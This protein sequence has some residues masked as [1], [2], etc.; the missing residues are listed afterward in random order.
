[1]SSGGAYCDCTYEWLQLCYVKPEPVTFLNHLPLLLSQ[2]PEALFAYLVL[3]A[4][5]RD[6]SFQLRNLTREAL[7]RLNKGIGFSPQHFASYI[8]ISPVLPVQIKV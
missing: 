1:M 7:S 8:T 3:N 6:G 4:V 5:P 2:T